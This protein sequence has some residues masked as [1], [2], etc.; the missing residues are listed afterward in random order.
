MQP[1]VLHPRKGQLLGACFKNADFMY[2]FCHA[3]AAHRVDRFTHAHDDG[4]VM[5]ASPDELSSIDIHLL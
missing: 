1:L 2:S 4:D 5:Y 3:C